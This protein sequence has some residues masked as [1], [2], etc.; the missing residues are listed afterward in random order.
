VG[1]EGCLNFRDIGGYPTAGG[2]TTRW[3]QVYRSDSLHY[4]VSG[5]LEVFER[6]AVRTVYDLRRDD[7]RADA[8]GPLDCVHLAVPSKRV[9]ASDMDDLRSRTDGE[10]WLLDDYVGMLRDGPSVWGRLFA[11]LAEG[12]LTPAVFHCFSGKDRTGMAAALLLTALEVGRATVLDDYELTGQYRAGDDIAHTVDFF[13][14]LGMTRA[15]AEGIL[16]APRWAMAE[17]LDHLDQEY[18]GINEYLLGPC[19]L[20]AAR[21]DNLRRNLVDE[22][23][24]PRA[25]ARQ[26]GPWAP[27]PS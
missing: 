23:S 1:F 17:A 6:L 22:A 7:E 3:G 18:G 9:E 20:S 16:S 21:L 2:G 5:D 19:G 4:F 13:V 10:R 24:S 25:A 12:E 11:D 14:G 26:R 27:L 15:A 8:P